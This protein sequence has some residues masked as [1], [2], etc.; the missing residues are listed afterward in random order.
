V[1]GTNYCAVDI[2]RFSR[3]LLSL[4]AALAADSN[5]VESGQRWSVLAHLHTHARS[6][7]GRSCLLLLLLLLLLWRRAW[8]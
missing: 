7:A 6:Q 2:S 3:M 1:S 5:T 4:T 8:W